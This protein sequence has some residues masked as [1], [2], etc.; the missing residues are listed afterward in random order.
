MLLF[1]HSV[2]TGRPNAEL[3]LRYRA[4]RFLCRTGVRGRS[5]P[6][7]RWSIYDAFTRF[8]K[9]G[10]GETNGRGVKKVVQ[11]SDVPTYKKEPLPIALD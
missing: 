2:A 8:E 7:E 3:D 5:P 9:L 4:D 1:A 6:Q 11:A 10:Q